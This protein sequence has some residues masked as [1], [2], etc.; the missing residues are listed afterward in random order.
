MPRKKLVANETPEVIPVM[1]FAPVPDAVMEHFLVAARSVLEA[2][3]AV[4]DCSVVNVPGISNPRQPVGE[5]MNA[6]G[7]A[8]SAAADADGADAVIGYAMVSFSVATK[9]KTM[10]EGGQVGAQIVR[11]PWLQNG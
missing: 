9:A 2:A 1:P 7:A 10:R 4:A 11:P 5:A 6:L 3:W 8:V